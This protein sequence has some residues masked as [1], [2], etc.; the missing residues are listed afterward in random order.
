[1]SRINR[2]TT[3]VHTREMRIL[4][5]FV[6]CTATIH[7][8]LILFV[9]MST[10]LKITHKWMPMP[11]M[12]RC[13]IFKSFF[14]I[15]HVFVMPFWWAISTDFKWN[16]FTMRTNQYIGMSSNRLSGPEL[17]HSDSMKMDESLNNWFSSEPEYYHIK[18][19]IKAFNMSNFFFCHTIMPLS[20][21]CLYCRNWPTRFLKRNQFQFTAI[22]LCHCIPRVR[23]RKRS[24]IYVAG[25]GVFRWHAIFVP[26]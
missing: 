17:I 12:I 5:T 16:S 23:N 19:N 14:Y 18:A 6:L 3:S 22:L 9:K 2:E 20:T 24:L 13:A 11:E 10:H 15:W 7:M 4:F 25:A 26:S 21:L 8:P 1:M